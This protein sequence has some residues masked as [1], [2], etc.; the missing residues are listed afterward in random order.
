MAA[1]LSSLVTVGIADWACDGLPAPL[2]VGFWSFTVPQAL[3]VARASTGTT[4]SNLGLVGRATGHSSS[5]LSIGS[6]ARTMPPGG[7]SSQ[8]VP[9]TS[10]HHAG[11]AYDLPGD[12]PRPAAVEGARN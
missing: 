3:S 8:Q 12:P 5:L 2:P 1:S 10:V 11:I 9:V 7:Y 4:A 6:S